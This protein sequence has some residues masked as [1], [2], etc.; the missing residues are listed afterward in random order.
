MRG[1]TG[2]LKSA[3]VGSAPPAGQVVTPAPDGPDSKPA[4]AVGSAPPAEQ[5]VAPALNGLDSMPAAAIGSA[6]PAEQVVAPALDALET[7]P[8]AA[9]GSAPPAEQIAAPALDAPE[10]ASTGT[11][12]TRPGSLKFALDSQYRLPATTWSAYLD[13]IHSTAPNDVREWRVPITVYVAIVLVPDENEQEQDRRIEATLTSIQASKSDGLVD[14]QPV[15]LGRS[16]FK[17]LQCHSSAR[18]LAEKISGEH[19]YVLFLKAGDKVSDAFAA[20]LARG[21]NDDKDLLFFDMW[22]RSNDRVLPIFLPGA[23]PIL[24]MNRDYFYSRFLVSGAAIKEESANA[25]ARAPYDLALGVLAKAYEAKKFQKYGHLPVP[26]ICLPENEAVSESLVSPE[27]F[28]YRFPGAKGYG[29]S[30]SEEERR[31]SVSVIICTRNKGQLLFQLVNGLLKQDNSLIEDIVIVANNTDNPLA[32]ERHR[33]L[34]KSPKVKFVDFSQPFN[35]SAQSNLGARNAKGNTL[36]FLNDDIVPV[37]EDWV[38]EL[39]RPLESERI[40]MAGALLLYP[41]ERVQHAG[42]FLGFDGICG[43]TLRH[44]ALPEEDYCGLLSAPRNVS[45]TTGACQMIKRDVFEKLNGFDEAFATY[46]QDV[47]LCLRVRESGYDIA[48]TPSAVLLHVESPSV[49]EILA[50]SRVESTRQRE[51][52]IFTERWGQVYLSKDPFHNPNFSIADEGLREIA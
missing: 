43:H 14:I 49:K 41:N 32:I 24:A 16:A 23:N 15:V 17:D 2:C 20:V 7:V 19:T 51:R 10:N 4:A 50:D 40:A 34:S 3:F 1:V 9:I 33:V 11:G 26:I 28:R 5:V 47:D 13:Y 18:E 30:K 31:P 52:D 44:A 35:F 21:L 25:E 6:P 8:A 27:P 37:T 22:Q 38:A 46:I 36:L 12:D 39:L 45:C 29:L 42:M 48:W